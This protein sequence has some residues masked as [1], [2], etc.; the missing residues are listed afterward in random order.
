VNR[1]GMLRPCRD[2]S[3]GAAWTGQQ[4]QVLGF[5]HRGTTA[6]DAELDIDVPGVSAP[7]ES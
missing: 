6:A 5:A 2:G 7:S 3:S 1:G 4:V